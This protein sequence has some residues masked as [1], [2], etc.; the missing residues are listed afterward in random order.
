MSTV[1]P[2]LFERV[3]A[4]GETLAVVDWGSGEAAP[5]TI[6]YRR[7][8]ALAERVAGALRQV[9]GPSAVGEGSPRVAYLV[10]PSLEWV[11]IT[12]GIWRA[13]GVAIP[14]ALAHPPREVAWT[15]AD[16]EADMVIADEAL[17]DRL[18]EVDPGVRRLDF[19][20]LGL[21]DGM[22]D[23]DYDSGP[24]PDTD[25]SSRDLGADH[26]AM[27]LYTSG[28]TGRPKGVV[29]THGNLEAQVRALT[30][31][32]GWRRDDRI[33]EFL[34][35][36]HVHGIVNVLTCALWRG[37]V[38][39]ILPRFDA[40]RVWDRVA[41]GELTLLMAV[42]AI[43]H[44]LARAWDDTTDERRHELSRAA[45]GL[46]LMVSGSAALPVP[47][48]ERW[49]EITGHT[50][51]ERYG[52]TEI[53]MAL[54]NPLDGPRVPGSVGRALPGVE[55]RLVDEAGRP[56]AEGA[57]GDG[58]AGQI[59]VRGPAV[60]PGYWRREQATRE[61]FRDGGWFVTGDQ[62]VREQGVWRI[63]GRS[64]VD[65]L[66]SGGEKISALEIE[67][68]LLEHPAIAEVAVVGVPDPAW[69]QAVSAAVV[70]APGATLD[71]ESLRGWAKQRLATYKVPRRLVLVDELP[72]NALGK[73]TKPA[74]VTLFE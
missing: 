2:T 21:L 15:V 3:A 7:L 17:A 45:R 6:D 5:R 4:R 23:P 72:R 25:P 49:R 28:T 1:R 38:C 37:A 13:G 32:W 43:Y 18:D 34:P 53:G 52:M 66:K 27:L 26:P 9:A 73:V 59:E 22:T 44:R 11:A 33:L 46:R 60:F 56:I 57:G 19:E 36:H 29:I 39:E 58:V 54:S 35:L 62:A 50:L 14:L 61:A 47:M 41:S 74:V 51:L 42:P 8:L 20:T 30:N 63:L 10:E 55:V 71:L 70:P 68:V 12:W 40:R 65:I 48:L 31:A 69:G 64:S 24:D 67:S 16:G